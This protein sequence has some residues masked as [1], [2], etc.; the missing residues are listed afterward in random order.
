[1]GEHQVCFTWSASFLPGGGAFL[2][3]HRIDFVHGEHHI[4]ELPG[5]IHSVPKESLDVP[6][7]GHGDQRVLVVGSEGEEG[8]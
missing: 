6:P 7:L 4:E 3:L 2:P 8:G 1:M 5:Y